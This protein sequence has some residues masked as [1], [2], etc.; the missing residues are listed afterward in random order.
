MSN[1]FSKEE[2]VAFEQ[3]LEGFNDLLVMSRLVKK[4]TTDQQS[5]ERSFNIIWRPQPYISQSY[6]GTDMTANFNSYTQMSV[7]AQIN[8]PRSVPWTMTALELRDALQEGRLG[9]AAKQKL[10]SDINLAVNGAV[11]SLGSLVSARTAAASGFDDVAQIDSI[12]NE[13]GIGIEDRYVAYSSRDYNSMASN[14]AARQTLQGKPET[15]YDK[16]YVGEVANFGVYK[17]DYAPRIAAAAGGAITIGAANQYYVPQATVASSYGEVTNVDNRFQTIVVS[18]TANV[19]PGDMFRVAG[20]NSVHHITKQ[21]TGIQKTFRV[22]SV[23]DGTH[24]Q[25]TPP[26][27]SGQGGSNAEVTYQNVTAT[28]AN[29]AAITWLNT[30]AASLNPFWKMDAVELLPGRFAPPSDAGVQVLRATTEQ[31]IEMTLEKFY[32]INTKLI[33]YRADVIFGV[34]VLQP[35]MCGLQLFSQTTSQ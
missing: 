7:P 1:A 27:I 35:E 13:Q 30:A 34:A 24:L 8:Q 22:V 32:D 16:A 31:G 11:T 12:F 18:A 29:G 15:A 17:M 2:R 21:D 23:V 9:D 26:F 28:P 14:L 20:V 33:K 4:Y 10:A 3:L 19:Q 5:M 6:A 25:I